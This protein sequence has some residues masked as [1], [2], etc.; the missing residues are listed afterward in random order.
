MNPAKT[1]LQARLMITFARI[2]EAGSISA[3]AS[4]FGIDKAGVSRQ[5]KELE[6]LLGVRLLNRSTR[7]L[8]ITDVGKSVLER[9]Q[10]VLVEVENANSEAE[11]FRSSPSG[12]LTVSASVAFGRTKIVPHL[13]KFLLMYP[14]INVELC[15]LDRHVQL[16]EEG[17]DVL[18]RLCDQP[19]D[20]LVA[21]LL[22]P[23]EYSL[24][25]SPAYLGPSAVLNTPE[26]L[27]NQNCLFY[28]FRKNTASWK[29]RHGRDFLSVEVTSRISVNSSDVVR[30]LAIDG[31]GIALLPNYAIENDLTAGS[32]ITVLDNFRPQGN[33]GDAVYALHTPSRFVSPKIRSFIQLLRDEWAK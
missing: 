10:R 23:I 20:Q 18:I 28:A 9:A 19:P 13:K 26:D 7:Q 22:G 3:A 8:T 15:L 16:V 30:L 29:F 25:C 32:L 24:V 5:L 2:V 17:M 14:E 31:L 1:L 11:F 12:L 33:L 27:K 21:H 4:Q 6:D